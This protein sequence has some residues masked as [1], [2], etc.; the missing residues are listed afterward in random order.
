M[1]SRMCLSLGLK[2]LSASCGNNQ[3]LKGTHIFQERQRDQ[4]IYALCR[5]RGTSYCISPSAK[6]NWNVR[7]LLDFYICIYCSRLWSPF[8]IASSI[9]APPD[10]KSAHTL[11]Y[12]FSNLDQL[13]VTFRIDLLHCWP[14]ELRRSEHCI[15]HHPPL[16][17]TVTSW[18]LVPRLASYLIFNSF[19]RQ[20]CDTVAFWNAL[21][22]EFTFEHED[23]G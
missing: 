11:L 9:T 6:E 19:P 16:F 8:R 13:K 15:Y 18:L 7:A 3:I 2:T 12:I 5:Y 1:I 21:N 10:E 14:F 22:R 20:Q 23:R 17:W 4:G